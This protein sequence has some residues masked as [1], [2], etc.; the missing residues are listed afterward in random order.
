MIALGFAPG[1]VA[2]SARVAAAGLCVASVAA[3]GGQTV[4]LPR[5]PA[6]LRTVPSRAGWLVEHY[7]DLTE[8]GELG[9]A[10]ASADSAASREVEQAFV[11]YLSLFPL[12]Q[13]DSL[14]RAAVAHLVE[15]ADAASAQKGVEVGAA[16]YFFDLAEKYLYDLDSPL[17]SE[18][19]YLWFI[20]AGLHAAN[21]PAIRKEILLAQ[22]RVIQNN[23]VGSQ[24]SDFY[25]ETPTGS[26]LY[27]HQ[28][29]AHN[30][31]SSTASS[32]SAPCSQS[33]ASV[34]SKAEGSESSQPEILLL[35]FEIGCPN[36]EAMIERLKAEY[37][38]SCGAETSC[39][40]ELS[41]GSDVQAGARRV[42]IVAIALNANVT[43]FRAYAPTLPSGWTVGYDSTGAINGTIF[44]IRHL[45]DLYCLTPTG[46]ILTKHSNLQ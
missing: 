28:L 29:L 25:F 20:N 39:G 46:T 27:F 8:F 10:G 33:L 12:V 40:A 17:A 31:M 35:F 30:D 22:K 45:P 23:P 9:A 13:S 2:A 26:G 4:V 11:N 6:E 7:W 32:G 5:P 15:K 36:C 21:L 41:T 43:T 1:A 37:P 42:K 19:Q 44:A 24:I 34:S 14:C 16:E 3:D 38:E 18:E